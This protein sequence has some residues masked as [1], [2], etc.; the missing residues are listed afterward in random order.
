LKF[1][2]NKELSHFAALLFL[3]VWHGLHFGYYIAFF[4]E[5]LI[6]TRERDVSITRE[7]L[8]VACV[9]WLDCTL[10]YSTWHFSRNYSIHNNEQLFLLLN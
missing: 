10:C 5:F 1:L 6:V 8:F 4:N 2:G 9:N 7:F 3:A